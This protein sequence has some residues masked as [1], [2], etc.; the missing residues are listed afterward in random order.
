[1]PKKQVSAIPVDARYCSALRATLRGSRLNGSRVNGSWTK[2]LMFSVFDSRNGSIFAVARSGRRFMSDSSMVVNPRMEEPSKARPSSMASSSK[3]SAGM[4]KCCSVPG[5]S[6][7]RMSTNSTSSSLMNFTTSSGVSNATL[8]SALRSR[9]CGG[10][11]GSHF[12]CRYPEYCPR[13]RRG[14]ELSVFPVRAG[15]RWVTVSFTSFPQQGAPVAGW[16]GKSLFSRGRCDQ[17]FLRRQPPH[18]HPIS[19][20]DH[21]GRG[22]DRHGSGLGGGDGF[23]ARHGWRAAA[24]GCGGDADRGRRKLRGNRTGRA[25][26]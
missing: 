19:P 4:L 6:V 5:T 1:A 23:R 11:L 16:G 10:L 20:R 13:G 24:G 21:A 12:T 8:N 7:K 25:V 9:V 26:V 17:L 15:G 14:G 2:N 3:A 18:N 22:G